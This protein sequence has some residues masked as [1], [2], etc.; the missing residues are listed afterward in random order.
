MFIIGI[1]SGSI[2]LTVGSSA[3]FGRLERI[4]D[5]RLCA[6]MAAWLFSMSSL[7]WMNTITDLWLQVDW[8][9]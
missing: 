3:S 5:T 2:L 6:S 9:F 4:E 8:M 1:E 7:N